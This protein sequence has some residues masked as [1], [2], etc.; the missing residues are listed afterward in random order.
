MR[1]TTDDRGKLACPGSHAR[2]GAAPIQPVPMS[3]LSPLSPH[4]GSLLVVRYKQVASLQATV[5]ALISLTTI[6]KPF[7]NLLDSLHMKANH[8][9]EQSQFYPLASPGFHT[10]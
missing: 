4:P 7:C 10:C 6:T 3:Q 8:S 2:S 5:T 1:Q 9:S